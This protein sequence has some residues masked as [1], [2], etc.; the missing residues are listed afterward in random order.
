M[1]END[2]FCKKENAFSIQFL[3]KGEIE[4]IN[5]FY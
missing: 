4:K 5:F 1:K 3:G 2:F